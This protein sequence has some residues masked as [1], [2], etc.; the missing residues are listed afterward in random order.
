MSIFKDRKFLNEAQLKKALRVK[1]I[2]NRLNRWILRL[3][4]LF[5]AIMV[6]LMF[7][8]A[9]V[10]GFLFV[11]NFFYLLMTFRQRKLFID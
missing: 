11:A 1:N 5:N 8:R 2:L 7:E 3:C 10:L 4:L 6:F 9:S